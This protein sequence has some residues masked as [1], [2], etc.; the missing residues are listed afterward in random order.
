MSFNTFQ[1]PFSFIKKISYGV[2]GVITTSGLYTIH[3]FNSSGTFTFI[4][5][6]KPI[7]YLIV[8]G[9]GACTPAYASGASGGA[10]GL[11]QGS[12]ALVAGSYSVTV[13]A[14]GT[15]GYESWEAVGWNGGNSSFNSLTAYGG[16]GGGAGDSYAFGSWH[17]NRYGGSIDGLNGGSGGG[18]GIDSNGGIRNGNGGLGI[19]GQGH[20][21]SSGDYGFGGGC[22]GG[23]GGTST[24]PTG[25]SGS[26]GIYSS[27]TG[28][29]IQYGI[30]GGNSVSPAPR[31]NTG[32][33]SRPDAWGTTGGTGVVIIRY[34]TK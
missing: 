30:G 15:M 17:H 31:A 27:I 8:G 3:T 33:G 16:G 11:L 9:G 14:G 13:G 34:L 18:G 19:V 29:S 20:N 2:G 4:G 22:G 21:G 10:G 32:D 5:G 12:S 1:F 25:Y 7:D 6:S 23:A 24:P 26:P 28:S